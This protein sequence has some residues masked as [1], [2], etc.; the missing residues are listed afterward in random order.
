M[1]FGMRSYSTEIILSDHLHQ[2]DQPADTQLKITKKLRLSC[3]WKPPKGKNP[4]IGKWKGKR[5]LFAVRGKTFPSI[6]GVMA[7]VGR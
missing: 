1:L 4:R 6:F 7:T 3:K 2:T 5:T